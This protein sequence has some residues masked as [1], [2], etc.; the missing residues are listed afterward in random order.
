[1]KSFPTTGL[2]TVLFGGFP[3]IHIL[4]TIMNNV[5]G[6]ET[7]SESVFMVLVHLY[8]HDRKREIRAL[9]KGDPISESI[10]SRKRFI[11][12][13]MSKKNPKSS[14]CPQTTV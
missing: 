7:M 14:I 3:V 9:S 10:C 6:R 4:L 2:I 1:M 8:E 13:D 5:N 11:L 12:L